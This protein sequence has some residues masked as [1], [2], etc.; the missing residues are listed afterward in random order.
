MSKRVAVVLSG[1]GYL[2]GSEIHEAT[3]TL[4]AL[5]RAGAQVV[6]AAPEGVAIQAVDH[7]TGQPSGETRD[8]L[9]ESARIARGKI[10][11]LASV[12]AADFDAAI[13][14]GGYGAAKNLCD[15]ASRGTEATPHPE[16]QRVM[17]EFLAAGKPIGVI[18][19]APALMAVVA[20]KSGKRLTLT[21]GNDAGTAAA[22]EALGCEH[23]NCSVR[24]IVV[25]KA[26]KVVS[27]PAYM[28]D[29]TPAEVFAGIE[30]LAG[31]VLELAG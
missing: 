3:L 21:I 27:T 9:A 23:L 25:D 30:K 20:N 13:F 24:D 14:P 5:D 28:Y 18:C 16:A 7:R 15:F 8:A 19:I 17:S 10:V 12:R 26:N 29:A 22:I 6:C 2:D 4:L 11:P 1:C 31:A